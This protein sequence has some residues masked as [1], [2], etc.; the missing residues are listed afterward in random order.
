M[1]IE[2]KIADLV[3][4]N[5]SLIRLGIDLETMPARIAVRDHLQKTMDEKTRRKRRSVSGDGE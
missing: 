1:Q 3:K 4:E 2:R 5:K